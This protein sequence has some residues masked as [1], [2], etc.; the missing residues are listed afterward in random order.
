MQDNR[1]QVAAVGALVVILAI[2]AAWWSLALWPAAGTGPAWV[3]RTRFACFGAE[4][5]GL[6]DAGGWLVM[7]GQPL[8]MLL[9]LFAAWGRDLRGGLTR[10]QRH[11]AGQLVVGATLAG[12]IAGV[13]GVIIRVRDAGAR[14][15]EGQPF[16][17]SATERLAGQLTWVDD[18]VP[19]MRLADQTGRVLSLAEYRGKSVLV[20]FAYAHCQTVCP[21]VVMDVLQAQA[22][23]RAQLLASAPGA[24][25]ATIAAAVPEVVIV[26]LDPLRDTPSRL[27]TMAQDWKLG[28]NGHVLS[29]PVEDVERVLNAWRVPRVRN[30]ATGDLT[31]P[32]MVYVIGRDGRI[33]Y[34]VPGGAEVI[35]A[36]VKGV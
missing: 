31:H 28:A 26:T 35:T 9:V 24:D 18:S 13:A 29:G 22:S 1:R 27:P 12:V 17:A 34:A 7:I 11:L 30:P 19:S 33:H 25:S 3:E 32:S 8:G 36:A 5:G 14:S 6:P 4:P 10:V 21:L 16:E 2:T 20:T 15:L 23:V